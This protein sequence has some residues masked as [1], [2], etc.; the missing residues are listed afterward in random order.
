M[1][2]YLCSIKFSEFAP[3]VHQIPM[4][5]RDSGHWWQKFLDL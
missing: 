3:Q 4:R 1:H 2:T 5:P